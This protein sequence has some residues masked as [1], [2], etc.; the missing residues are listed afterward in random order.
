MM[1]F[2]GPTITLLS[3][4]LACGCGRPHDHA[5]EPGH[6]HTHQHA[7]PHGGMLVEVGDHQFNVE[8]VHDAGTGTLTLY[9]LDAHAENFVRTAMPVI[10]LSLTAGSQTHT[11]SLLPVANPATGETVGATSQY[12]AE[13]AWLKGATGLTGTITRLDFNGAE[14]IQIPFG[15]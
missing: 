7:A 11:L 12:Q 13:A 8:L 9:T 15:Q 10:E 4:A 5:A 1:R 14:F 3:L 2:I 6:A